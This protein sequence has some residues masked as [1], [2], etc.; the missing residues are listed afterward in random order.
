MGKISAFLGRQR[1]S[2]VIVSGRT[3]KIIQLF[4]NQDIM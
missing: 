3:E 1:H 4:G 2:Y